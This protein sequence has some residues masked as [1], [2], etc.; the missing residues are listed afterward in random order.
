MF[1]GKKGQSGLEF[2]MTYGWAFLVCILV[3]VVLY[4]LG[5]IDFLNWIPS[6]CRFDSA[7]IECPAFVLD[8]NEKGSTKD[9]TDDGYV[10]LK[11]TNMFNE[12]VVITDCRAYVEDQRFC[13]DEQQLDETS[14]SAENKDTFIDCKDT[15]WAESESLN[16]RLT[17]CEYDAFKLDPG[18]KRK[19]Q[20]EL[21]YYP[22]AHG[23]AFTKTIIGDVFTLI[24]R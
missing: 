18:K 19:V 13:I 7:K 6:Y 10:L 14:Y 15:T 11:L 8:S 3:V 4:S 16:L 20:V 21:E 9:P 2:L 23:E 22:R 1:K 17:S 12:P 24:E 5:V